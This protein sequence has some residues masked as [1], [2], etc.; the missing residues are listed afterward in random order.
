MQHV[1]D[2]LVPKDKAD[3]DHNINTASLT[4]TGPIKHPNS[5]AAKGT[6]M[7]GKLSVGGSRSLSKPTLAQSRHTS[8]DNKLFFTGG[9]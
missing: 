9:S 5:S 7:T 1:S 3:G 2:T 4:A 6:T 8:S